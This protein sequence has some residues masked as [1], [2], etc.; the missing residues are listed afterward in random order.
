M[1]DDE[2]Q[3][4]KAAKDQRS[5]KKATRTGAP[6]LTLLYDGLC[7]IC[8]REIDFM[9]RR[10]R[11]GRIGYVDIAAPDFEPERFGIDLPT[12]MAAMHGVLPDGRVVV[13]L[14]VF[15]RAYALLGL[16]FLVAWTDWPLLR[17]VA[18]L[19]YRIFARIRPRLSRLECPDG[20]CEIR[21]VPTRATKTA[22]Q[23]A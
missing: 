4:M 6:E 16:R 5:A 17:P 10:D 2:V 14:E 19:G 11:A 3:S 9:R 23:K 1:T 13:G 8:R 12:A 22:G 21:P 7:P 18:N 20:R 15:R